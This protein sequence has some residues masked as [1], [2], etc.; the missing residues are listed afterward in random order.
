M[1]KAWFILSFSTSC[2][3]LRFFCVDLFFFTVFSSFLFISSA[4]FYVVCLFS[5]VNTCFAEQ[6]ITTS[7]RVADSKK[8][9]KKKERKDSF[10]SFDF[11]SLSYLSTIQ[12]VYKK[13]DFQKFYQLLL[14]VNL[15]WIKR[16]VSI[17]SF[18][19]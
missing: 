5:S 14:K 19:T 9:K 1:K 3:Q 8:K 12:H 18:L 16:W 13:R 17:F 7:V 6:K 11:V 4:M 10:I 2:L 15:S